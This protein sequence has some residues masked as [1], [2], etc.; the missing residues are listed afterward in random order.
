MGSVRHKR[1]MQCDDCPECGGVEGCPWWGRFKKQD[2]DFP[3]TERVVEECLIPNLFTLFNQS[4]YHRDQVIDSLKKYQKLLDDNL[5]KPIPRLR[6][7][8]YLDHEKPLA[9]ERRD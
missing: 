7:E 1:A 2:I 6:G 4:F 3:H 5:A 9:I 8:Q